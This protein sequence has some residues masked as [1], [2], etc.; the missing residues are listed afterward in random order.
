MIE[1]TIICD[2][3]GTVLAGGKTAAAARVDVRQTGGRTYIVRHGKRVDLCATCWPKPR[4][5]KED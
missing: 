1:I 2:D 3:C 5:P 4:P